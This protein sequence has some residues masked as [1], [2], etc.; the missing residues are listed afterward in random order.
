MSDKLER[1][2]LPASKNASPGPANPARR[3]RPSHQTAHRDA[4][5][6]FEKGKTIYATL[7]AACHQPHGFGLDGLAPPLVDS[8]WVLGKPE[9][10]A[11]IVM[12]GLAG[13]VKVSGRTYNLAMPPLPQLS[14]EDIAGVLTYI[15]R[16][17]EHTARR[18]RNQ[19]RHAIRDQEKGRMMMWT[20]TE[21]KNLG[22]EEVSLGPSFNRSHRRRQRRP[23]L[24]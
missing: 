21:L 15:R 20:E 9:M 1:R 22:Q 23:H 24:A 12:H 8:E 4:D 7:C 10:L 11:R 16:E 5:R 18:R 13:P 6:L 14:D 2:S 19:V 3:P 17:W